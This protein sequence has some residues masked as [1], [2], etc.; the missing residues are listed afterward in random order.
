MVDLGSVGQGDPVVHGINDRGYVYGHATFPGA[1]RPDP[2]GFFWSSRTGIVDIGKL[3]D[4]S[5]PGAMNEAGTIVG[6]AGQGAS[7]LLAFR[8]TL[9]TGISDM[10]TLPDE[11]TWA[12][13]I[14][15][16]GQ[17]VGATP[18][19]PGART[20]P[21][22]WTPGRGLL[23]LGVGSTER[24]AGT[25]VNDDGMVIGYLFRSF[26]VSHGFI[27]TW[28][29]GLIEIGAGHDELRTWA[30][31]VNKRGQVVGHIG[32]RAFIW[33]RGQGFIDLNTLANGAPAGL[34]LD[35]AR[36]ISESGAILA[37]ANSGLYLLVPRN[38]SRRPW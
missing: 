8:W 11:F 34:V 28:E 7:S 14:N 19:T 16:A 33:T 38:G 24:G 32:D 1:E 3:G 9:E 17:V 37:T 23:D 18:F 15:R 27:W 13:H 2:H 35:A 4:F 31:D 12:I 22:L 25:E 6:Y 30:S 21:F 36:A 10:G 5:I 29:T 26:I 20:H